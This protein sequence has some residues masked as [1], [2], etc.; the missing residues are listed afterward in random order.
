MIQ[1]STFQKYRGPVRTIAAYKKSAARLKNDFVHGKLILPLLILLAQQK[2]RLVFSADPGVHSS[3]V[4][5]L[6]DMVCLKMDRSDLKYSCFLFFL[7][8][9]YQFKMDSLL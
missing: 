7:G 3:E 8:L 1:M 2:T 5:N 4:A 6:Y 9:I